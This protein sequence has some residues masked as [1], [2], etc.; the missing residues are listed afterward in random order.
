MHVSAYT[1]IVLGVSSIKCAACANRI[2]LQMLA[3]YGLAVSVLIGCY[4]QSRSC[5]SARVDR[6]GG[7][8]QDR[9]CSL[10]AFKT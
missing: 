9:G 8:S 1:S 10:H 4:G 7:L 5:L 2:V 6:L 3:R